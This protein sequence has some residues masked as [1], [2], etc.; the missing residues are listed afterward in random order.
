MEDVL[1]PAVPL[2]FFAMMA[3]EALI[4]AR[5]FPTLRLWRLAG[6]AFMVMMGVLG[7][8]APLLLAPGWVAA[9]RVLDLSRMG[10]AGGA[11][12][13]FLALSFVN[14]LYHRACHRFSPLWRVFHQ[15]HHSPARVDMAGAALFHPLD[16]LVYSLTPLIIGGL[17]LGLD[18]RAA[19][20]A[21]F[22]VVFCGFFQ[23]WNVRTPRWLGY[24]V[25]RPESHCVHHEYGVHASNYSDF[26][27]WDILFGTFR[28]PDRWE[29]RAGFDPPAS[30][31]IGAM[32][33]FHDVSTDRRL[34]KTTT[35]PER[36]DGATASE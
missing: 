31:R 26:P 10:V 12:A 27:L 24:L 20:I 18:P 28:N 6:V 1:G 22:A 2:L 11:I 35:A 19:A 7:A 5:R 29:G 25:Q 4:P 21:G 9:H 16:G 34:H 32:L 17:L 23:H 3:V 36:A 30:R 8:A 33:L 13:G 14:C 15:L